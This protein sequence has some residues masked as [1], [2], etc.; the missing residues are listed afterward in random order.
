MTSVS[1]GRASDQSGFSLID[2]LFVTAI[3]GLLATLAVPGLMRAKGAAQSASA[4]GTIRVV[5]SAQL[6]FAITCGLGFYS[7]TFPPLALKP[8]GSPEAFLPLELAS[9]DTFVRSGYLF[10]MASDNVLPAAPATCNGLA[11]GRTSISYA[12][13]ADQLGSSASNNRFFGTNSDGLIFEHSASLSAVMPETGKP[14]VGM[15]LTTNK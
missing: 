4:L 3:V 9:G 15:P 8:A 10:S 2:L 14:P 13:V 5:N 11:A 6:S 1:V 12:L 7:A